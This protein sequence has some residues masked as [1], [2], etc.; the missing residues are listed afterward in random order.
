MTNGDIETVIG[1]LKGWWI[2]HCPTGYW[3]SPEDVAQE[4]WLAA[5]SVPPNRRRQAI[6][7]R[8]DLMIKRAVTECA[9]RDI[10]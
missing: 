3:I 1:H 2:T 8:F 10:S 7:R 5:L 9:A 6:R 4:L